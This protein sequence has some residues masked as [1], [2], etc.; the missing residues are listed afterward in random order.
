MTLFVSCED[1]KVSEATRDR[2]RA[3]LA[4]LLVGDALGSQVEFC[5]P[6]SIL[7]RYPS[8]VRHM[9]ASPVWDTLAGQPTDDGEMA[10]ALARA[11]VARGTYDPHAVW[12]AYQAWGNSEPFD[13]G[14]TIRAALQGRPNASSEANGAMMRAGP[15]ALPVRGAS[16]AQREA[17]AGIDARLTHPSPVCV[18]ANT[19][20]VGLVARGVDGHSVGDLADFARDWASQPE[21][22]PSLQRTVH[23][24]FEAPPADYLTLAGHVLVALQNAL[25]HLWQQD[26]P[27]AALIA[28]VAEG[29][30][31]DTNAAILGALLGAVHGLAA[32]PKDW[33]GTVLDCRPEHGDE[34]VARPRP[35]SC[36]PVDCLDLADALVGK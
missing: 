32:W 5:H 8:G 31:S 4:G 12:A 18:A 10:L 11:M 21:C 17:W 7:R 15:L 24:S 36:W 13:M 29:G 3:S 35:L 14:G 9:E 34:R 19:L 25:W 26:L 30:D 1:K 28:T 27:A 33:L 6:A 20:Y 22:P 16:L 2:A 23:L